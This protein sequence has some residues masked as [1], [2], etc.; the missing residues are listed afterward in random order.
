V[1][2]VVKDSSGRPIAGATVR[3][4]W[5]G[6]AA[7]GALTGGTSAAEQRVTADEDGFFKMEVP[8]DA[9]VTVTA[10]GAGEFGPGSI[11]SSPAEAGKKL[12]LF[13]PR[14]QAVAGATAAAPTVVTP[15]ELARVAFQSFVVEQFDAAERA[16]Q[17][18]L[19]RDPRDALAQAVLANCLAVHAV[20]RR[21]AERLASA[22][23]WTEAVLAAQPRMGLAHNAMGLVL[24]GSGD[25][26]GARRE[27]ERAREL[28][29]NLSVA[30]A[31]LGQIHYQ[32]GQY[33]DAEKDFSDA[34]RS[35]PEAA[36]P[37]NG[38]AQVYQA[39]GRPRDAIRAALAAISHYELR[40]DYLGLF[41]VNLAAA[42]QQAGRAQQ[43]LDAVARAKALGVKGNPTVE[44]IE[45]TAFAKTRR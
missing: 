45:R 9:T 16:A 34:I 38:L 1:F 13:L 22:R 35:R 25:L 26:P 28:E 24:Y 29:P 14:S 40:D 43:A 20:N 39:Q 42:L 33:P 4:V 19:T 7:R 27:F 18:A 6:G 10:G 36:V 17:N 21:D 2:G 23:K 32:L 8:R 5:A 37:Y 11:T 30:A 41:Y 3:V 44:M 15:Q 31:N 12:S